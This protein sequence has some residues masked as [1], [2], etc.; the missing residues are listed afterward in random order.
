MI[1]E[2]KMKDRIIPRDDV[3]RQGFIDNNPVERPG[4]SGMMEP[5]YNPETSPIFPMPQSLAYAIGR[6]ELEP[7]DMLL[8]YLSCEFRDQ[9]VTP[10]DF[11]DMAQMSEDEV[12]DGMNRLIEH[13]FMSVSRQ[14]SRKR[15]CFILNPIQ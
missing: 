6:G 2:A 14:Q 4:M 8:F 9:P 13:G 1:K 15:D 7:G 5:T 11:L 10:Q 3:D 12:I